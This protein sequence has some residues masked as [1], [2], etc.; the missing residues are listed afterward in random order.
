MKRFSVII[1]ALVLAILTAALMPAQ[2]FADSIPEYISEIKVYMGDYSAAGKEGFTVLK[3]E[4]GNPVDLNQKAGGGIGSKGN[5][6][7]YLGYKT[8]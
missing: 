8:T 5:V 2:V 7:V 1:I 3:G 6:A 4:D